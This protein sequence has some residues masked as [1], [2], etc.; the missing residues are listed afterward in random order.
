MKA[1]LSLD[2]DNKW[3]YMK[4][5]GDSA[6]E[7]FP[8]YL[9]LLV[10]RVLDLLEERGLQI[11]FFIVGQD[12]A[13]PQHA[14][15]LG[16]ISKRGHEIGNH[17]HY[18]EPWMHRRGIAAIEDELARADEAIEQATGKRPRGFRGPGFTRSNEILEV[19][20]RRG[21]LYDAS[22][23]PTFIG[24]LARAYYFRSTAL[25][26]SQR[27][28]REDLFG[29]FGDGFRRNRPHT[30]A[31]PN[32]PI[33]E[34]PVT[35]FPI[36]RVPIHISYVLYLAAVSPKL[37]LAYF[38]AAMLA[39]KLTGTEPSILLHPL[40]FLSG[41]EA[42][43]LRFFPGM[44]MKPHVKQQVLLESIDVLRKEF[45]VRPVIEMVHPSATTAPAK[46]A[47]ST[48]EQAAV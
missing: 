13:L 22:S 4:T 45:D 29:G 31:L 17:S 9:P 2:L 21:F 1:S 39:C 24:P 18:H 3:S 14:G 10:P 37:A 48:H 35:T 43:E 47:A 40:D 19:L 6:W 42:P 33:A 32:G 26:P 30:I 34:I 20:R 38:R 27:A 8:S 36:F 12:A 7:S 28:E 25:S 16:E 11:T 23:L 41:D 46:E 15:L 44:S 5:H